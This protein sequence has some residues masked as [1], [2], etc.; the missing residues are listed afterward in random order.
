MSAD[1]PGATAA[2]PL[3]RGRAPAK[4]RL[5]T[6]LFLAATLLSTAVAGTGAAQSLTGPPAGTTGTTGVTRPGSAPAPSMPGAPM[7]PM[8]PNGVTPPGSASV[9]FGQPQFQGTTNARCPDGYAA[10]Q[11]P[12]RHGTITVCAVVNDGFD[13]CTGLTGYYA[14][15]RHG[16]ECCPDDS[17]NSCFAG[18]YPCGF[19]GAPGQPRTACCLRR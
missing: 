16:M 6:T 5:F 14:C 18:A 3:A 19:G 10:V 15:G 2:L 8:T 12:L 11:S 17:D 13:P 4:P 9:L 1:P 7:F